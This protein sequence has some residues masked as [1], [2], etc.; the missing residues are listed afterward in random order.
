MIHR[1]LTAIIWLFALAAFAVTGLVVFWPRDVA[2]QQA[3]VQEILD[4]DSFQELVRQEIL[5]GLKSEYQSQH[6]WGQQ[7][8]RKEVR[9]HGKW[10][11]PRLE[12]TTKEV[13]DGL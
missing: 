13:N 7:T 4:L 8:E 12:K 1:L 3:I 9:V 5:D 10:F 2:T 6:H 11:D